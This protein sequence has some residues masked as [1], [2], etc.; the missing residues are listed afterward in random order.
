MSLI[1]DLLDLGVLGFPG[2]VQQSA[3]GD[4]GLALRSQGY[5]GKV[6]ELKV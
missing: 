2:G 6:W 1:L 3:M 5:R 4:S